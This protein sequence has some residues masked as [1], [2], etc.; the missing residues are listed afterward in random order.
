M[1]TIPLPPSGTPFIDPRTNTVHILW[2]NYLLELENSL[3][4]DVAPKD[5]QYWVSTANS[6]LTAERNIGALSS[7]FLKITTAAGTATPS[8]TA[9][10]PVADISGVLPIAK[11]GTNSS[12]ALSGTTIMLSNGSAIVQ[13]SA[14]TTTTVLHGNAG[15]APGYAAVNLV[16]DVT[17]TLGLSNGGTNANNTTQTYTPTLT[18]S[19]N[20]TASTAYSTGYGRLGGMVWVS[21]QLAIDPTSAS[22]LTELGISLPI[23]SNFTAENECGGTAACADVA[24]YSARIYAD[25]ANNRAKLAFTT[26][27]DVAS[28]A[29]SF[30]FGYQVI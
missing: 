3:D 6:D 9:T 2:Q 19:T 23:A 25:A 15:G 29:W 8:T 7:G 14:G 22:T 11:G 1:A 26:G 20:V 24:G 17:G 28:R 21:G 13:G 5:A 12:A 16:D 27:A 10:I 4:L 30:T 18:D